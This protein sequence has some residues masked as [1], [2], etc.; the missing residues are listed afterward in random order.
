M[1]QK[2]TVWL[3]GAEILVAAALISGPPQDGQ[4]TW[5]LARRCS[6]GPGS[7][8]WELPGG[9]VETGETPAAALARELAEEMAVRADI[10][11]QVLVLT[12]DYP[13]QRV[14]LVCLRVVLPEE[15]WQLS[16]HD[17]VRFV[18]AVEAL[19]MDL[20]PAD[21]QIFQYLQHLAD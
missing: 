17:E 20:L 11:E 8:F 6:P 2:G 18:T 19:A 12:H 10:A 14:I 15:N 16:V 13:E 7:G 1:Y 21:Y 9:K 4:P 5:L 3:A